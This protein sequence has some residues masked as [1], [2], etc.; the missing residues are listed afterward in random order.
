MLELLNN[1]TKIRFA[2]NSENAVLS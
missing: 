1:F 2:V